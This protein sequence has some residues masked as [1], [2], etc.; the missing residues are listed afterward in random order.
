MADMPRPLVLFAAT[1]ME[2]RAV[3]AGLECGGE[4]PAP[5]GMLRVAHRGRHLV[6]AL[7]GVGP[8]LAAIAAGRAQTLNP[9]G[10]LCAGIAGTYIP[11]AAPPGSLAVADAEIWPEYGLATE[12]GVDAAALGFPL[13]GGRHDTDP[14]PVWDTLPL[15]PAASFAA[16]GLSLPRAVN[17]GRDP[18]PPLVAFGPS[19]TVAAASGTGGRARALAARHGALTEN[20]EGFSLALAARLSGIPFIEMRSISNVVGQRGP[21]AWNMPAALASLSRAVNRAF[22]GETAC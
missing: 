1:A 13:I 20:M 18:G 7:T 2:M 14:P 11:A 17:P 5:G 3:I 10:M 4:P 22:Y 9:S 21:D 8:V 12:T 15:D 6:L 19:L 16:L